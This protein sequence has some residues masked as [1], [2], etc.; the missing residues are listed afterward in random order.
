V[1]TRPALISSACALSS[2]RV[3]AGEFF[4]HGCAGE[5]PVLLVVFANAG[6]FTVWALSVAAGGGARAKAA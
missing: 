1:F 6:L 4:G 3:L 2:R 5:E